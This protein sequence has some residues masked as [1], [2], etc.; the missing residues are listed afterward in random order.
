MTGADTG[1]G[2]SA[3]DDE[4]EPED[5]EDPSGS[6]E[7]GDPSGDPSSDDSASD[8]GSDD[9]GPGTDSGDP[10]D[11]SLE[12]TWV[13]EGADIAPLLAEL[14]GAQRIDASFTADTFTVMTLDAEG[15]MVEQTGVYSDG[16]SGFGGI[17]EIT[18]EQS[19]P[20]AVTAE[21]IY[22][23]DTSVDPPILRYEIVQTMPSVGAVPPTAEGGFGSTAYGSDLTQIFVRQ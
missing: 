8:S 18:L 16:A 13:S 15:Q 3:D 9:D 14:T 21:G 20:T 11:V 12:G 23:V 5:D 19:T 17:M 4:D 22:E 1:G 2:D 10:G 6:D 7:S